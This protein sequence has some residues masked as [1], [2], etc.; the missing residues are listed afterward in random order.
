MT[1]PANKKTTAS[2]SQISESFK[3]LLKARY[4]AKKAAIAKPASKAE[5][6]ATIIIT[7]ITSSYL[8]LASLRRYVENSS[9]GI[10]NLT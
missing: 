3:N 7:P 4:A 2:P 10:P 5:M 9:L 8:S 1:P 6:P